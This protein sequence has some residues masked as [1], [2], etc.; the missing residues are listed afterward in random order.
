MMLPNLR[1]GRTLEKELS[2][3]IL[4]E[5]QKIDR[6]LKTRPLFIVPWGKVFRAQVLG[7]VDISVSKIGVLYF[8]AVPVMVE[9][10]PSSNRLCLN[11]EVEE[12][13]LGDLNE[14][15]SYKAVM[16]DSESNKWV[17]AMNAE[18]QSMMDNM[19]MFYVPGSIFLLVVR[20]LGAGALRKTTDMDWI[21][22]ESVSMKDLG[23]TKMDKFQIVG[24]PHARRL[25]LNKSQGAQTPKEV[26]RMKNVPYASAVGV[27]P[28]P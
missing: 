15:A 14:P 8:N 9:S 4:L 18:I 11:V 28:T 26:N 12:H 16:L 27:D 6:K 13:S 20:P 22:L 19:V 10:N 23:D 21:N 25:D 1:T 17:D 2:L 7:I 24:H 3:C 5:M